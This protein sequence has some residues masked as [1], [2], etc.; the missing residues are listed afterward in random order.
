MAFKAQVYIYSVGAVAT[1]DTYKLKM[2][3]LT[4]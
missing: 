4:S 1:F 2:S 3:G